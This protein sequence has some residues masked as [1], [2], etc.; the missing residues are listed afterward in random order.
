MP[1]AETFNIKR[2]MWN[3]ISTVPEDRDLRV[4]VIDQTGEH[5]VI[6]PCRRESGQWINPDTG[7]TVDIHPTHWRDWSPRPGDVV[8]GSRFE[9]DAVAA[10]A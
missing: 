9:P 10:V 5:V 2:S 8:K 3:H 7:R 1:A 6:F 4:A